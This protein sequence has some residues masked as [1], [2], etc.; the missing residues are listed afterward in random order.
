MSGHFSFVCYV[1]VFEL[2]GRILLAPAAWHE[3][4]VRIKRISDMFP[5]KYP[6]VNIYLTLTRLHFVSF[7]SS[8][9]V[10]YVCIFH[11]FFWVS[12]LEVVTVD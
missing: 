12:T 11:H 1:F 3:I 5:I 9:N 10:G 2:A 8:Q 6:T 7:Q 4:I